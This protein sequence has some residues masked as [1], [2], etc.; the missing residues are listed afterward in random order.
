MNI[1]T[2]TVNKKSALKIARQKNE[3]PDLVIEKGCPNRRE[4]ETS[5]LKEFFMETNT[6]YAIR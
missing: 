6:G 5:L 1:D 3:N 2:E 4:K